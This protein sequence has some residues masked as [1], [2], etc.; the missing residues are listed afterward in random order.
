M[1]DE[2]IVVTKTLNAPSAKV[3]KAI[4]DKDEMKKWYFDISEFKAVPGFEFQFLGGDKEENQFLHLCKIMEVIPGKKLAHSWRYDGYEAN[5]IVTFELI[6][7]N[8]GRTTVRLTHEGL[9]TFPKNTSF[10]KE[11]FVEGWNHIIGVS[12]PQYLEANKE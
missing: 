9:E 3:W 5:S 11:N 12:L 2:P 6:N 1:K 10:A 8:D 4:T 7:E